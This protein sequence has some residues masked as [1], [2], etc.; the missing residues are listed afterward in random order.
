MAI[1]HFAPA[2]GDSF[3][4]FSDDDEKIVCISADQ[5]RCIHI[6][7]DAA[8]DAAADAITTATADATHADGAG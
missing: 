1:D 4:A 5:G 7:A 2:V 6:D 3:S 8:A